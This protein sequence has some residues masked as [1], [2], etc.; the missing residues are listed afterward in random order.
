MKK[1]LAMLALA[2]SGSVFAATA[3]LEYQNIDGVQN[4]PNNQ[5]NI[6]LTVKEAINKNF[7]IIIL[8]NS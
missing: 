1:I 2:A 4:T 3:T 5:Q 7:D 6:N 8:S